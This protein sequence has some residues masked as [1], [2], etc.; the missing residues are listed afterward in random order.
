MLQHNANA[1]AAIVADAKTG[2]VL[3]MVSAPRFDAK[4]RTHYLP[5]K[6]FNHATTNLFPMGSLMAPLI[7][8]A[9]VANGK[10]G[11]DSVIATG[12]E[13]LKVAGLRIKDF[14]A[15]KSLTVGEIVA[16][17]SEVGIAKLSLNLSSK[18]LLD[19]FGSARVTQ[20]P[21]YL[22][23]NVLQGSEIN[24]AKLKQPEYLVQMG[25][26][27]NR[28]LAQI[29]NS[30]LA[31]AAVS[32]EGT[33]P[34]NLRLVGYMDAASSYRPAPCEISAA[35]SKSVREML[36]K[37]VSFEGTAPRASVIGINV[38]GK[39]ATVRVPEKT[40]SSNGKPV[41]IPGRDVAAFIGLAPIEAPEI[42]VAVM[43]QFDSGKGKFAGDSAAPLFS[44][45]VSGS[46]NHLNS[47]REPNLNIGTNK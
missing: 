38:G 40:D 20:R 22:G 1:G 31:I 43:L 45:I 12:S 21:D 4:E 19:F 36:A 32:S 39:T 24:I 5:E 33:C 10:T 27:S 46:L 2:E 23:M 14:R 3:A 26:L 25:N 42:A 7:A 16:K 11:I 17:S 6:Y 30:Y 18:N 37:S 8:G 28:S 41:K 13:G 15:S 47:N 34:D 35:T 29:L 9:S 44:E